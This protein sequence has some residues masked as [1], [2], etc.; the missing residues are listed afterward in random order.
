MEDR[1]VNGVVDRLFNRM[2]QEA[3][4]PL[5]SPPVSL[6]NVVQRI[7]SNPALTEVE[8]ELR[9]RFDISRNPA[10]QHEPSGS[11]TA[12]ATHVPYNPS[13]A[14]RRPRQ[15]T[16]SRRR[17]RTISNVFKDEPS[18]RILYKDFI[19][20]PPNTTKTPRGKERSRLEREGFVVHAVPLKQS[21]TEKEIEEVVNKIF[22]H[23]FVQ[24]SVGE[25][26]YV[27]VFI[28]I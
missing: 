7:I 15:S 6:P 21:Q 4:R 26:R 22:A 9:N 20:L 13:T 27:H 3:E 19:L 14:Y 10:Q 17:K 16:G 8:G 1:I 2:N 24:N 23:K 12:A 5:N 25:K 18:Q 11:G 28:H